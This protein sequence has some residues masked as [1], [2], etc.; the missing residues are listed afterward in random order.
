[1][2]FAYARGEPSFWICVKL[3]F[4]TVFSNDIF[5]CQFTVE[6]SDEN[7]QY[8]SHT[9]GKRLIWDMNQDLST[10]TFSVLY[11][12]LRCQK[13]VF[14]SHH[15][16]WKSSLPSKPESDKTLIFLCNWEID[17]L[18][19]SWCSYTI[20]LMSYDQFGRNPLPQLSDESTTFVT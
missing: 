14:V 5:Q 18:C 3:N 1:M 6:K 19:W 17:C 10:N 4:I 9:A 11:A 7:I 12:L 2:L 16:N 20:K 13:A 8:F 15:C